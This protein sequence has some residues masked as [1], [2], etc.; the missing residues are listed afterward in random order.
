MT[1]TQ[2]QDHTPQP[3]SRKMS[4]KDVRRILSDTEA[5]VAKEKIERAENTLEEVKEFLS[6]VLFL[7][8]GKLTAGTID[9]AAFR[10]ETLS[11]IFEIAM[12]TFRANCPDPDRAYSDFLTDLGD[13]VGLTFARDLVTRLINHDLFLHVH[14]MRS[15]LDLW[16]SFENDTGAGETRITNYGPEHITIQLRNNPLRRAESFG[17]SHCGFYRSYLGSLLNEMFR[18]RARFLQTRVEDIKA[19]AKSVVEI[20]ESPDVED[21]CT[22][23]ISCRAEV[24]TKA[25]DF[26]TEAYD[27]Y[28]TIKDD[29]DFSV[30]M[31]KARGALVAAQMEA[32]GL[33]E[34]RAP[35][36]LYM[37]YKGLLSP[38]DF[39]RMHEVFQQVSR[40]LH[41]EAASTAKLDKK[42]AWAH[43]RDVRRTVYALESLSLNN[44]ERANLRNQALRNDRLAAIEEVANKSEGL[45]AGARHELK[46]I[47]NHL[48]KGTQLS[49]ERQ[50]IFVQLL[51]KLG[52]TGRE[53]ADP[54][55]TEVLTEDVKKKCGLA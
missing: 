39:K 9:Y 50:A 30:C 52:K 40:V 18:I 4:V 23:I 41:P 10:V 17:H 14:D 55:L 1:A 22:F 21:Q 7:H 51:T 43:L 26:L 11:L 20:V 16:A 54:V 15:L 34:E 24:L 36:Q 32:I 19:Q 27:Q 48:R 46:D 45:D 5:Q 38:R 49:E 42:R 13:E 8:N 28:Y 31:N 2:A 44:E 35:R 3:V 6:G 33:A 25:F 37:I 29:E 53:L 12:Q 47:L